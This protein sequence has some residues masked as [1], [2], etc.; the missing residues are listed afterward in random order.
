[1]VTGV[2]GW[3]RGGAHGQAFG[4]VALASAALLAGLTA[5]AGSLAIPAGTAGA[6]AGASV[7]S[8]SIMRLATPRSTLP[9]SPGTWSEIGSAPSLPTFD[10]TA[11]WSSSGCMAV[12]DRSYVAGVADVTTDGGATWTETTIPSN[13]SDLTGVACPA[14]STCAAVGVIGTGSVP[15]TGQTAF[16]STT[17]GG[18]TWNEVRIYSTTQPTSVSCPSVTTC[19]VTGTLASTSSS[20]GVSDTVEVTNMTSP[21]IDELMPAGQYASIACPTTSVC[22]AVGSNDGNVGAVAYTTNGGG[23]WAAGQVPSGVTSINDVACANESECVA[24][25][26]EGPNQFVWMTSSSQGRGWN[27]QTTNQFLVPISELT[28]VSCTTT[29]H[30]AA[31]G[32]Q[33]FQYGLVSSPGAA[34][35]STDGG[36][37][38]AIST[39]PGAPTDPMSV[40]CPTASFCME[41]GGSVIRTSSDGG[42]TWTASIVPAGLSLTAVSCPTTTDCTAVGADSTGATI[43]GTDD[44]WQTVHAETLPTSV[45]YTDL[46]AISCPTT[47]F[48]MAVGGNL[49]LTTTDGGSAWTVDTIPIGGYSA[50][51]VTCARADAC[52]ISGVGSRYGLIDTATG[53]S[54]SYVPLID[55]AILGGGTTADMMAV[56]CATS[57]GTTIG[58]VAAGTIYPIGG[59][60]PEVPTGALVNSSNGFGTVNYLVD[61]ANLAPRIWQL[62]CSSASDCAAIGLNGISTT[63]DG[64][65]TWTTPISTT[66]FAGVPLGVSCP[67]NGTCVVVGMS[68]V[69]GGAAASE[70]GG[71]WTTGQAPAAATMMNSVSCPDV[72]ACFAT[73]ADASGATA[74]FATR[75]P[76]PGPVTAIGAAGSAP[77]G[78]WLADAQGCVSAHGGVT[79]LGS[80]CGKPLNAPITH[81]VP[82][83]DGKGYWLVAA[84]G[85]VF[86]FGDAS[87]H[88][89]MGGKPLNAPVVALAATADGNGYWLVASDGGV[90]AFGDARYKG[91]MGGKPLNEPV[92]GIAGDPATGGY[93]LVASDGGIFAFGAPFRGSTG[94]LHLNQPVVGMAVDPATGG[95]W[96]VAADG[97]VFAFGAPFE[98]AD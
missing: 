62:S 55:T 79:V 36:A 53:S 65:A 29:G 17:D 56:S 4:R 89:S 14:A 37:I 50:T 54:L 24:V 3:R 19:L 93:W 61:V 46:A 94:A 87:F 6:S 58:C 78:Y 88:G 84:D 10:A 90:F 20:S 28:G 27:L 31:V 43:V 66:K 52:T 71:S 86:C 32:P 51:A 11:C 15:S 12:G 44:G 67:Q 9:P 45:G 91:S 72:T 74:V 33:F 21:G 26:D 77:T 83:P 49:I 30:C 60:Q 47:S 73:G 48:C 39:Q 23:T 64:G 70:I 97:G 82:T 34:Y 35:V 98:G 16:I 96:L 38:W 40:A 92:V 69:A 85:G 18:A 8:S 57:P 25:G 75:L 7:A 68:T 63:S 41:A 1:M 95:Y 42:S 81:L 59:T 2:G 13:I 22:L 5:V 76:L 80:M